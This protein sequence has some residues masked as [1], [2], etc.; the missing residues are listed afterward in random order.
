[1]K[2]MEWVAVLGVVIASL[3]VSSAQAAVKVELGKSS[4]SL[5]SLAN[6]NA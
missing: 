1:M 4:K 6:A 3:T 5:A 2:P